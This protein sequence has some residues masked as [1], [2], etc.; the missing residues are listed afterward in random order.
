[1]KRHFKLVLPAGVCILGPFRGKLVILLE[2]KG[3]RGKD[4]DGRSIGTPEEGRS[5]KIKVV[6]KSFSREKRRC[7]REA[8]RK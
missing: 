2:K 8:I 6:K 5:P 3:Q 7:G 4:T 1:V